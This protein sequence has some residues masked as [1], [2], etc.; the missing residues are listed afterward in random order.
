MSARETLISWAGKPTEPHRKGTPKAS[1]HRRE[2]RH[3][4]RRRVALLAHATARPDTERPASPRSACDSVRSASK[5][6][7]KPAR[8]SM[9]ATSASDIARSSHPDLDQRPVRAQSSDRQLQLGPRRQREHRVVAQ[10]LQTASTSRATRPGQRDAHHRAHHATTTALSDPRDH[11]RQQLAAPREASD[12]PKPSHT[13]ER[14]SC[15]AQSESRLDFPYPAARRS[16]PAPHC[17]RRQTTT[18]RGRRTNPGE[19]SGLRQSPRRDR[20]HT[21]PYTTPSGGA[22]GARLLARWPC[23]SV[24]LG[25]LRGA[26]R[27]SRTARGRSKQARPPVRGCRHHR[28]V[29][30]FTSGIIRFGGCA[31][32][33][34]P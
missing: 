19:N 13:N 28:R 15:S 3:P 29:P 12:D 25:Q 14:A 7:S 26:R 22:V 21:R 5:S 32:F 4:G 17:G 24:C 11:A 16:R 31:P 10:A 20:L 18:S 9:E 33:K 2:S 1:D 34:W 6:G 8:R 23:R 27:L 30:E